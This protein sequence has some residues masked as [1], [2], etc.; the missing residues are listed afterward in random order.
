VW[1]AA[2]DGVAFSWR[3]LAIRVG[4][5]DRTDMKLG[6]FIVS[7]MEPILQEW[8]AFARSVWPTPKPTL[9]LL[10]DHAEAILRAATRDMATEQTEIEQADK[11]KGEGS[12][13]KSSSNLDDASRSHAAGRVRSGFHLVELVSEYRAL[14]ASVVRLWGESGTQPDPVG[15]NDLT[16]FNECI[17][18]SL[19]EAVRHFSDEMDRS[20]KVFLGILGHDLRNPLNAILLSAQSLGEFSTGE[21]AE[22]VSQIISS[23]SAMAHLLADFIDFTASRLGA[24]IPL[25]LAPTD[26]AVLCRTVAD[27]CSASF[28]GSE[29]ILDLRGAL[30]GTWDGDRL[31]QLLSNLIGNAIQHGDMRAP[32]HIAASG[33][34]SEVVL[35]IQN[36]G[37]PIPAEL[38]PLIFDP[39]VQTRTTDQAKR[40][41][42]SMGLGLYIAK[43][44]V[45]AHGG[46]IR[47]TSSAQ[48]GTVFTVTLPRNCGPS[49]NPTAPSRQK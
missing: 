35:R 36:A 43:E 41:Y 32:V 31:R 16:R 2:P 13:G 12:D 29:Y 17:D 7:N 19:A 39:L 15:L 24:G 46:V 40:R 38:L 27:E 18:Q 49:G 21:S 4:L 30:A 48:A 20:R 28:P 25:V 42:G 37:E 45:T 8:E 26:L 47:V 23:G 11:S 34:E 33:E 10:R 9:I 22:L 5:A 1:P 6:N 14:R 44:V 3:R